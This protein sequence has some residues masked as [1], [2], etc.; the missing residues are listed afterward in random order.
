M[1]V[2]NFYFLSTLQPYVRKIIN[3]I[4]IIMILMICY[5]SK[6]RILKI[7]R[8]TDK[9]RCRYTLCFQ[10]HKKTSFLIYLERKSVTLYLSLRCKTMIVVSNRTCSD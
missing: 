6:D 9:T 2:N 8:N 5:L 7:M 1:K 10:S 3:I 4:D